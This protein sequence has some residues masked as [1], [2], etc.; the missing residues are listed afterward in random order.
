MKPLVTVRSSA[1]HSVL[2]RSVSLGP[3]GAIA[4][5]DNLWASRTT[6]PPMR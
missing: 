1:N 4:H 3:I 2:D 5:P 6:A